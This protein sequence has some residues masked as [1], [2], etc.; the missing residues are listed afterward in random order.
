[1]WTKQQSHPPIPITDTAEDVLQMIVDIL[2][3]HDSLDKCDL[4]TVLNKL[5]EVLNVTVVTP[6]LAEVIVSIM[7]NILNSKSDL[8]PFTNE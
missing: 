7:S 4:Q 8:Q 2:K 3:E 6:D 1:M 5:Q